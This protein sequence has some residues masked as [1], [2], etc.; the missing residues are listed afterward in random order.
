[1][2]SPL[3]SRAPGHAPAA[4]LALILGF[5]LPAAVG[6]Q[7]QSFSH[8]THER[9][10]CE[11]CHG[12]GKAT[13]TSQRGLC[14]ECHRAEG[15]GPGA[16]AA[17]GERRASRFQHDSHQTIDCETCHA[18]GTGLRTAGRQWCAECHHARASF[19]GCTGCHTLSSVRPGPL[20]VTQRFG[21]EGGPAERQL[22]FAHERHAG[23][24]CGTCHVDAIRFAV[25]GDCE[26]C[27][28]SH[29]SADSECAACHVAPAEGVHP[30]EVHWAGCAGSGCHDPERLDYEALAGTRNLCLAC[31][32]DQTRHEPGE[33]CARCHLPGVTT[34]RP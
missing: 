21:F 12:T 28:Q 33:V 32:E 23:L 22:R 14:A 24:G 19:A 6:A 30:V 10:E 18:G 27:H 4:G 26:S 9:L 7:A 1:M 17:P 15:G 16:A 2:R 20:E 25:K 8:E 29:H 5:A 13:V 31:H 11:R 34:A 3:V